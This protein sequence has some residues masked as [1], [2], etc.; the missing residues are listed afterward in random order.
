MIGKR[1]APMAR[2]TLGLY[3]HREFNIFVDAVMK[4]LLQAM[5]E[6]YG[7]RFL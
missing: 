5:D 6:M 3:L 4:M 2:D 1:F 7:L